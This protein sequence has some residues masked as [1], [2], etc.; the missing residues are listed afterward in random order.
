M[1][2]HRRTRAQIISDHPAVLRNQIGASEG[3]D[4]A[5]ESQ[6][7]SAPSES[8]ERFHD[9]VENIREVFWMAKAD[10]SE[11]IYI[12][13]SYE[14]VWGRSC[15]SLYDN[16]RSWMDSVHPL[17]ARRIQTDISRREDRGHTLE[18]RIIRADG[19]VRWILDRGFSVRKTDGRADRIAGIAEDI[20]EQKEAEEALRE[21]EERY[22]SSVGE[23]F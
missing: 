15:A 17:D 4:G 9:V 6:A 1:N 13:P 23:L 12:S 19:A 10:L 3:L 16:P 18:Y 7:E 2:D 21:S 14:H 22:R 20:T 8:E 5:K 11:M